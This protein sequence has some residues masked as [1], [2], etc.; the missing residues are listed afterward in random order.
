MNGLQKLLRNMP[1]EVKIS[2]LPDFSAQ[3]FWKGL[4][5]ISVDDIKYLVIKALQIV[6]TIND[7]LAKPF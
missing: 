2:F 5:I 6:K 3:K 4:R 7:N 1:L